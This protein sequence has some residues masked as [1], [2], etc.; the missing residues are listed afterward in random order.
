MPVK[1]SVGEISYTVGYLSVDFM[2]EYGGRCKYGSC[3]P[4]AMG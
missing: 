4:W 1:G 2:V 3:Q